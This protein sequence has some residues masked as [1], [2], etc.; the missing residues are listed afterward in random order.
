MKNRELHH[1]ENFGRGL[2]GK[3]PIPYWVWRVRQFFYITF[4]EIR[5]KLCKHKWE[6]EDIG[7]PESGPHIVGHCTKCGLHL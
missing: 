5:S 2:D 3:R 4:L 1:W 6:I 7:G